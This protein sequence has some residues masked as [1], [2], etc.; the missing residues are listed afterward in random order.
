M[1]DEIVLQN[2]IFP[3][4]DI[5][6]CMDLYVSCAKEDIYIEEDCV[7]IKDKK[8]T[9]FFTYFNS[10]SIEKWLEYTSI[11][12]VSVCLEL[13]GE[14]IIRLVYANMKKG[15]VV[16]KIISEDKLVFDKRTFWRKTVED[17]E[18]I[19]ICYVE[20]ESVNNT[21]LYSGSYRAVPEKKIKDIKLAIGICTYKREEYVM[22]NIGLI[23]EYILNNK[24]LDTYDNVGL[25]VSDNG[26]TL[27]LDQINSNKIKAVYNK[28]AGGA[29]GFTRCMIEAMSDKEIEYTHM[30]LMDDDIKIEPE[31]IYRTYIL[32]SLAKSKY[33]KASVGGALLRLDYPYIQHENGVSWEMNYV[34]SPKRGYMLNDEK[35]LLLNERSCIIDFSGWWYC[36]MPLSDK[37]DNLPLPIFIHR[38]DMEYGMRAGKKTMTLNGVGVWH[39]AGDN[40]RTSPMEYYDM[41][42]LLIL[43]SLHYNDYYDYSKV[44]VKRKVFVHLINQMLKYRYDDQLLT[45]K[46]VEDFL[47]GVDFLKDTEPVQLNTEISKHGYKFKDVS[48]DLKRMETVKENISVDRLYESKMPKLKN[49]LTINGWFLPAKRGCV[50]LPAGCSINSLYRVKNVLYYEPDTL[51]GFYA[52][53]KFLN[54]FVTL[55]RYIKIAVKINKDFDAA[56]AGYRRR[57]K[58]LLSEEFWRRYLEI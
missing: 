38:D 18:H 48:S 13:S 31:V 12:D 34:N 5:C 51:K 24:N 26:H 25:F 44:H 17:C 37:K 40:R 3:K 50:A 8:K 15:N 54:I 2:F 55:Y 9:S 22:Q 32:L 1:A 49:I 21:I 46:G 53:R 4:E 14:C 16:K 27:Q 56:R 29:G 36:A 7:K 28:N 23:K 58:E 30:L 57:Y 6:S 19:G 20:I 35:S 43:N 52:K 39:D 42:N 33:K 11:K 45:I 41:R 10:L 47:K